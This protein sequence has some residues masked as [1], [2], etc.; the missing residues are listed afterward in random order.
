MVHRIPL[1]EDSALTMGTR[2]LI[3]G[4]YNCNKQQ[5]FSLRFNSLFITTT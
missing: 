1:A 4:P 2:V 3:V 5:N